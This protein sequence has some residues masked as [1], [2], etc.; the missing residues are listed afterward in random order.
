M[1]IPERIYTFI[2]SHNADCFCDDCIQRELGLARRQQVAPI[3]KTL[4][5]TPEFVRVAGL[6]AVCSYPR[7]KL[8]IRAL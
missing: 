5:L 2:T 4:G 6:C 7:T 1:T 3:T 8:V